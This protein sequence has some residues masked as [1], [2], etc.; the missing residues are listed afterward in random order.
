MVVANHMQ[1]NLCVTLMS[2]FFKC[3]FLLTLSQ[4]NQEVCGKHI[5]EEKEKR[6][7]DETVK[8][9]LLKSLQEFGFS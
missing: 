9:L 1:P 3:I 8:G 4:N 5:E 2:Y 7:R 6:E